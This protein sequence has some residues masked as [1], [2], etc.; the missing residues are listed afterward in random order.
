MNKKTLEKFEQILLQQKNNLIQISKSAE[1]S[2]D[3]DSDGDETDAIQGNIIASLNSQL[4]IRDA[5]KIK[6]I[7]V[8]LSKIESKTFGLCEDCNEE[9]PEKRLM[10]NPC[11][12]TCV[13]CAEDRENNEIRRRK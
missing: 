5:S 3:I 1:R 13:S 6:Q 7:N 4:S 9:I 2:S 8:A 11:S 10:F 12:L